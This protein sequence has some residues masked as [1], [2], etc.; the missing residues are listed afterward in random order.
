MSA[1]FLYNLHQCD[2]PHIEVPNASLQVGSQHDLQSLASTPLYHGRPHT[3][4]LFHIRVYQGPYDTTHIASEYPQIDYR[5]D[6]LCI[7]LADVY[8]QADRMSGRTP[9]V[10]TL[11]VCDNYHSYR[12]C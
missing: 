7:Q 10:S 11:M 9:Q 2:T 12:L 5:R 1:K 3:L 8:P 6:N 4:T